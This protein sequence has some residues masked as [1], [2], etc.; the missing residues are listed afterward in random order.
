MIP[1]FTCRQYTDFVW[2]VLFSTLFV[3]L[4]VGSGV[5]SAGDCPPL[6]RLRDGATVGQLSDETLACLVTVRDDTSQIE[7]R[8]EASRLLIADSHA[9]GI[10]TQWAHHVQIHLDHLDDSDP[11][12]MYR[13]GLHLLKFGAP[14]EAVKRTEEAL[15]HLDSWASLT[16]REDRLFNLLKLRTDAGIAVLGVV[17]SANPPDEMIIRATESRI[18]LYAVEW[19]AQAQRTRRDYTPALAACVNTSWNQPRCVQRATGVPSPW[20]NLGQ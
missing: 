12:L 13:Y 9:K 11:D 2:R 1:P 7:N 8:A 18:R 15:K 14:S 16:D 6:E 4:C 3:G 5:A 20:T 19:L 10:L 17:R